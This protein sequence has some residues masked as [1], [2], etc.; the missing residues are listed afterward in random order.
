M[1]HLKP[2]HKD[3][4]KPK[5]LAEY[6]DEERESAFFQILFAQTGRHDRGGAP[7]AKDTADLLRDLTK[8]SKGL[9]TARVHHLPA[10]VTGA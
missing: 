6:S 9:V 4:G 1:S 8:D 10:S 5:T 7:I 3:T 2:V